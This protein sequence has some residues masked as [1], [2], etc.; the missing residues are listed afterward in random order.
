MR[1]TPATLL[2][3]AALFV[4]LGGTA[5]AVRESA[6]VGPSKTNIVLFDRVSGEDTVT[7][8]TEDPLGGPAL[9]ARAKPGDIL[10]V[11]AR[12]DGFRSAGAGSCRVRLQSVGPEESDLD[13]FIQV[14]ELSGTTVQSRY[15]TG[16]AN[17]DDPFDGASSPFQAEARTFAVTQKGDYDFSLRYLASDAGT[18]CNFSDRSLHV[19]VLR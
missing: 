16:G 5:L 11:S 14:L 13:G 7:G 9:T 4:A 2:A 19:A 18:T 1:P 8:T 10:M 3:L 15:L 6:K 12:V 17:D